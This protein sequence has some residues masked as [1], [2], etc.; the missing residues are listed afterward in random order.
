MKIT[1]IDRRWSGRFNLVQMD[2]KPKN[3][4][5]AWMFP[6]RAVIKKLHDRMTRWVKSCK[7][8]APMN[9]KIKIV[10]RVP[11][12]KVFVVD[13]PRLPFF[14]LLMHRHGSQNS[15]VDENYKCMRCGE[16]VPDAVKTL[17]MM[18]ATFGLDVKEDKK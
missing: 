14:S 15:T 12:E 1:K 9:G 7:I 13:E 16:Q 2:E 5:K 4:H 10:Y 8:I 18:E 3:K 17:V 6:D 11:G